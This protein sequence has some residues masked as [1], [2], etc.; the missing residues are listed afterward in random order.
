[1]TDNITFTCHSDAHD[2]NIGYTWLFNKTHINTSNDDS[3]VING[4]ELTVYNVTHSLGGIYECV[5]TN[6]IG[7]GKGHSYLFGMPENT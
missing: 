1:M 6:L 5:V 4:P 3:F 7:T 2:L